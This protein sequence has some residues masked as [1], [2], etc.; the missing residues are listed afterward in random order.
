MA[1]TPSPNEAFFREVDDAVRQDRL[2]VFGKRYG[3]WLIGIVL[4]GLIAFGGW[5]YWNHHSRE[6]SGQVAEQA[7]D[8]LEA[9]ATG[10]KVDEKA[11]AALADASQP[12]YRAIALL[13]KAALAEKQGDVK[14]AAK[15]Y[16]DIAANK[17]MD[18]AYRDL[19]TVRQTALT[20]DD[21]QPQQVVDRLKPLAVEGG[22]WFGSA[23][24]M[25]AI[26]YMKMGKK[27]LA[28]P[29]FAAIAKDQ[30]APASLRSRAR[31]MAGLMGVDAVD[32]DNGDADAANTDNGG[33]GTA[34]R[35]ENEGE[36]AGTGE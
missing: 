1:E 5:L 23:G 36:D 11:L 17:D 31:Q 6:T 7:Q 35:E 33:A 21:L 22:P 25:T 15:L 12:G 4:A 27:N 30:K 20:F 26:A 9:V 32:T 18:Q 29:L 10:G 19:G 28:G 16:G 3:L 8:V 34:S 13:T 14:G 24:E 2:A